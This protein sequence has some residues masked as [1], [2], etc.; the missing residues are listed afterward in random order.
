M[1]LGLAPAASLCEDRPSIGRSAVRLTLIVLSLAVA[2]CEHRALADPNSLAYTSWQFVEIDGQPTPL[3]GDLLRD[4][5]YAVDF[6]PDV[7]VGYGG[8]NRFSSNYSLDGDVMT[9]GPVAS[10]RRA[11][12]EPFMSLERRLFEI[13]QRPVRIS[14]PAPEMLVLTGETGTVRL[15]L[16]ADQEQ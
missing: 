12:P 11:C 9:V 1:D 3:T 15:R 10:T 2:A 14:R 8:C 5:R 6:G 4:D 7:M 13:L 16:T